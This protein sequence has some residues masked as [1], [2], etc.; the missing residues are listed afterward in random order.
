[1]MYYELHY[2]SI[3]QSKSVNH[4]LSSTTLLA[5]LEEAHAFDASD[6]CF[7]FRIGLWAY[8]R[9]MMSEMVIKNQQWGIPAQPLVGGWRKHAQTLLWNLDPQVS[10]GELRE[11]YRVVTSQLVELL[12]ATKAMDSGKLSTWLEKYVMLDKLL[13]EHEAVRTGPVEFSYEIQRLIDRIYY[14]SVP[15]PDTFKFADNRIFET[16]NEKGPERAF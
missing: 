14:D 15:V 3:S 12:I 6:T 11:T 4:R 10:G 8:A 1:M 2:Y 9:G 7:K 5:A 13:A 16:G